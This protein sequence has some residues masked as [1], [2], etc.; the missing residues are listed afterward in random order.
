MAETRHPSL[1]DR[2]YARFG[3][4]VLILVAAAV[5]TFGLILSEVATLNVVR[6][7]PIPERETIFLA[8][9]VAVVIG[10]AG[11]VA[12]FIALR[13]V[14]PL[15]RTA[16]TQK[17][18]AAAWQAAVSFPL[19]FAI[20]SMTV[21]L[22]LISPAVIFG[23]VHAFGFRVPL[24]IYAVVGISQITA[25]TVIVL[26]YGAAVLVRPLLTDLYKKLDAL[27]SSQTVTLRTR[28]ILLIPIGVGATATGAAF[29]QPTRIG[30][31]TSTIVAIA[32]TSAF[33]LFMWTPV[34]AMFA[35]SMLTPIA[36]LQAATERIRHGDYSQPIVEMWADELGAVAVSLNEA[37]RGLSERQQMA[38]EV[39]E[40]RA[41]IVAAAD[42]S[43]KR[44]ERNIHDGAQ[45]RLVA[46]TLDARL[47][48]SQIPTMSDDETIAAVQ[49]IAEGLKEALAELRD[50]ARGL[51]PAILTTDGLGPALTQLATRSAVPVSVDAPSERLPEQV[52]TTAYFVAAEALANVAKYAR[53]SHATVTATH[54]NGRLS[55]VIAD[56]GVGGAFAA[57]GSGLSGL[58]DRVAAIGGRLTVESESGKGTRITA[59]LPVNGTPHG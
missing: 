52:E 46:L 18:L 7:Q 34:T 57:N 8:V 45:Q 51:H 36:D 1:P 55:I 35:H 9:L 22:V 56:D 6:M 49:Q 59:D 10:I 43:R 47:L 40:S 28:L 13:L 23:F 50:L 33:A 16:R 58:A 3:W 30:I 19:S 44:I 48:E 26:I 31:T 24:L 5:W 17:D 39:R 21:G 27:P 15:R 29:A 2:L 20:R 42:A 38:R 4:K 37:M 32:L 54:V 41:R 25:V 12:H 53:A 11:V 14:A